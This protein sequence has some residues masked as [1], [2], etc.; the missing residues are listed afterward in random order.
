MSRKDYGT[1]LVLAMLA[2]LVGGIVSERVFG[3]ESALAQQRS[4]AVTSEE[5]LLV[6]KS[7]RAR[8]GL[9]LD[10]RGEVGLIL[11]SKD[12]NR[13]LYLTPDE[14]KALQL[15]DKDGKVLWAIP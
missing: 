2:G 6:D 8:A 7:G 5:Y 14:A 4:K 13:S 3:S 1:M 15:K 11:L 9:G 12:G 10:A